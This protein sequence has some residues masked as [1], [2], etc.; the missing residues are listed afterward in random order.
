MNSIKIFITCFFALIIGCTDEGSQKE[1]EVSEKKSGIN[2]SNEVKKIQPDVNNSLVEEISSKP[3]TDVPE[4]IKP[5]KDFIKNNAIFGNWQ[6]KINDDILGILTMYW[7]VN[8]SGSLQVSLHSKKATSQFY[9]AKWRMEGNNFYEIGQKG[10]TLYIIKWMNNNSEFIVETEG[11]FD[12]AHFS[13][14]SIPA[15]DKEGRYT[16]PCPVCDRKC[17]VL[18]G[19][20]RDRTCLTVSEEQDALYNSI[21]GE[22]EIK[23]WIRC[24]NCKGKGVV[25]KSY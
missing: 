3:K 8:P 1:K 19:P 20:N 16:V 13:R 2:V 17:V 24:C 21:S 22:G 5:N 4:K 9:T 12:N 7:N 23:V 25:S 10:E 11:D 15:P 14:K 6:T 18:D